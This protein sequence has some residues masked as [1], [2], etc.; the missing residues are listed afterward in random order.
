MFL[1]SASLA[2]GL[3]AEV[4]TKEE[5]HEASAFSLAATNH[6]PTCPLAPGDFSGGE[7]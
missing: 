5:L 4:L 6:P 7:G 3:S 2:A 1:D